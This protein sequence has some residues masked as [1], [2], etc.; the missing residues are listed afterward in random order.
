[1]TSGT[2]SRYL[3]S[4]Q[5]LTEA[6]REFLDNV[7][8]YHSQ[9][10]ALAASDEWGRAVYALGLRDVSKI[11]QILGQIDEAEE[12]LRRSISIH[13][14]LAR[15]FPGTPEYRMEVA[16]SLLSLGRYLAENR[17]YDEALKCFQS[18]RDTLSAL[19]PIPKFQELIDNDYATALNNIGNIL[20]AHGEFKNA[21][22]EY[23]KAVEIQRKLRLTNPTGVSVQAGLARSLFN[24][25]NCLIKDGQL[26]EAEPAAAEALA[27]RRSVAEQTK[28]P[29]DRLVVEAS[30]VVLA[31]LHSALRNYEAA[32]DALREAEQIGQVL[33]SEYPGVPKYR[34]RQSSTLE[35]LAGVMEDAG[36][37]EEAISLYEQLVSLR[38]SLVG[39]VAEQVM[40]RGWLAEA[41]DSLAR[42]V[43]DVDAE[44][45]VG[46]WRAAITSFDEVI[47]RDPQLWVYEDRNDAL[48]HLASCYWESL[49]QPDEALPMFEE[50]EMAWLRLFQEH[51]EQIRF[52]VFQSGILRNVG[53]ILVEAGEIDRG[54][55]KLKNA[56]AIAESIQPGQQS[57]EV[58]QSN[59]RSI[60]R[61]LSSHE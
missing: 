49:K 59:V 17:K 57:Y 61:L 8:R 3:A 21:V 37:R 40:Y 5:T 32:I 15:D 58:A 53:Q 7:A 6:D 27:I 36:R 11:R 26:M 56:L 18:A 22:I 16:G 55:A 29:D 50:A 13:E 1:M 25:A 33:V 52:R 48:V 14:E 51:P 34:S 60:R 41:K 23:G 43:K 12:E 54:V 9:L 35:E 19:P 42:L 38:E 20:Q 46:L 10:G 45:A 24:L 2:V 44:R 28:E 47:A 31:R 4:R 30:L 39:Q